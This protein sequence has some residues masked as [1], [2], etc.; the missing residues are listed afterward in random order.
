[1]DFIVVSQAH[2]YMTL[3]FIKLSIL[4]IRECLYVGIVLSIS[5]I[6][7]KYS[8]SIH[9]FTKLVYKINVLINQY[10]LNGT[11]MES[12]KALLFFFYQ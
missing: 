9:S 12:G 2:L 6:K 1:M 4:F 3:L 7:K 8:Y 11:F 5:N 10:F